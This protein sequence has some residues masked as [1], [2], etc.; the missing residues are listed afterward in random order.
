MK[1]LLILFFVLLLGSQTGITQSLNKFSLQFLGSTYSPWT[2]GYERSILRS[3]PN[4]IAGIGVG[5]W[6]SKHK[7]YVSGTYP[8]E[9]KSS[10]VFFHHSI[11][12]KYVVP[13]SNNFKPH[14]SIGSVYSKL[15]NKNKVGDEWKHIHRLQEYSP[16]VPS[17]F[18]NV[19]M[20][21]YWNKRLGINLDF[22]SY[23]E[24][25]N[26]DIAMGDVILF[27]GG[28]IVYSF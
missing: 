10:P 12:C 7:T 28:G 3:K 20:T 9:Y 23:K 25:Q 15:V 2:L 1:R 11:Y 19:G 8:W 14:V 4:I 16:I 26:I 13:L 17:I 5:V 27:A 21:Y 6:K 22:Y 24:Y 18:V